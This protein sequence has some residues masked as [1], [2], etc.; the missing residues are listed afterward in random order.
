M[1]RY[2][3]TMSR[4]KSK[5]TTKAKAS[6]K[7]HAK[8]RVEHRR[9]AGVNDVAIVPQVTIADI[10]GTVV[11]FAYLILQNQPNHANIVFTT[12]MILDRLE[13]P[14]VFNMA[15][16]AMTNLGPYSIDSASAHLFGRFP[17]LKIYE[18]IEQMYHS[19]PLW[20]EQ[21]LEPDSMHQLIAVCC[22]MGIE[23]YLPMYPRKTAAR[24]GLFRC[25]SCYF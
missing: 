8:A 9:R 10:V 25:R 14:G 15:F 24:R 21:G 4:Q 23:R 3:D 2:L 16:S 18:A 20:I 19:M 7:A 6:A 1:S 13:D 12:L 5:A 11:T 22:E 17:K